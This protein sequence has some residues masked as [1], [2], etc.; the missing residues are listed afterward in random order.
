M[1][2]TMNLIWAFDFGPEIDS[3]TGKPMPVDTFNYAKVRSHSYLS[4][5]I[6][7]IRR[8]G[9]FDMPGTVHVHHH[10]AERTPRRNYQA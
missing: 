4:I 5:P 10:A 3:E 9:N 2:N 8:T 1:V 7:N 6:T